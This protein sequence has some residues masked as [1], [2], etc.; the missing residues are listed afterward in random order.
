MHIFIF[1]LLTDTFS[2]MVYGRSVLIHDHGFKTNYSV[3]INLALSYH[4]RYWKA[5]ASS[6]CDTAVGIQLHY[7]H[8]LPRR[9]DQTVRLQFKSKKK[10]KTKIIKFY[11]GKKLL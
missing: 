7:R 8:L 6:S 2:G 3:D 5:S 11:G 10:V 4:Y 9:V 1:F